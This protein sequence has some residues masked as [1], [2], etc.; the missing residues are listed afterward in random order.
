MLFYILKLRKYLTL[1]DIMQIYANYCGKMGNIIRV[2]S[3][4]SETKTDKK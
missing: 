3:Y 1:E 4:C 2:K